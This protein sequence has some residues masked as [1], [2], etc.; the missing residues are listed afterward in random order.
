[1]CNQGMGVGGA[2]RVMNSKA[3]TTSTFTLYSDHVRTEYVKY[4]GL[5]VV[6][7]VA[8]GTPIYKVEWEASNTEPLNGPATD[9]TYVIPEGMAALAASLADANWHVAGFNPPPA[10]FGRLKVTGIASNVNAGSL[11]AQIWMQG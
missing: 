10:S 6:A 9:A 3:W 4:F 8:S 11:T 7:S 2:F 1:M 5:R